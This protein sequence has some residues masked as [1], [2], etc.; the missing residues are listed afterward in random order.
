M[1]IAYTNSEF[2]PVSEL[3]QNMLEVRVKFDAIKKQELRDSSDMVQQTTCSV[4]GRKPTVTNDGSGETIVVCP[5]ILEAL[6]KRCVS[7]EPSRLPSPLGG[8]RI[9]V[10][11]DG[12][13]RW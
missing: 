7:A 8:V 12:P 6:K 4:C 2:P 9:E 1:T 5:H 10:F 13:A 11:D 3:L